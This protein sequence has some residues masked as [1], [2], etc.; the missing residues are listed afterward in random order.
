MSNKL[1]LPFP[2]GTKAYIYV[3]QATFVAH[4]A[5]RPRADAR[6][7]AQAGRRRARRCRHVDP[8][9]PR[10]LS[11][12]RSFDPSSKMPVKFFPDL[13]VL[14]TSAG[15]VRVGESAPSSSSSSDGL[16]FRPSLENNGG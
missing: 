8:R 12:T 9:G 16:R 7:P 15:W 10:R 3:N 1:D 4:G 5:L 11:G 6:Q 2:V 13:K 14:A